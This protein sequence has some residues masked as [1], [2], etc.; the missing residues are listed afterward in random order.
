MLRGC[1][2]A[3]RSYGLRQA[4]CDEPH[5]PGGAVSRGFATANAECIFSTRASPHFGQQG[6]GSSN[7]LINI[8]KRSVHEAQRYS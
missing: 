8:S 2:V 4:H 5:G 3:T 1:P 7:R 6:G